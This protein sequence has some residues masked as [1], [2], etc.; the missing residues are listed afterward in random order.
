MVTGDALAAIARGLTLAPARIWRC[1]HDREHRRIRNHI[2][3]DRVLPGP[4]DLGLRRK[5][6]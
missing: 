4:D 3:R 1:W 2:R 5:V 6:W